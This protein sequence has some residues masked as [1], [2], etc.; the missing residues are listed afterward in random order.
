M[1]LGII[2]SLADHAPGTVL[3]YDDE[4]QNAASVFKRGTGKVKIS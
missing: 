1:P 3:L 4:F 2:Q